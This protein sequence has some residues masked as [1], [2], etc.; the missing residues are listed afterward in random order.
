MAFDQD[1]NARLLAVQAG[2]VALIRALPPN[3]ALPALLEAERE[4]T[5]ALLLARSFPDS[6]LDA[7]EAQMQVMRQAVELSLSSPIPRPL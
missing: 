1:A 6:A 3:P 2:L 5:I 4:R 7:F